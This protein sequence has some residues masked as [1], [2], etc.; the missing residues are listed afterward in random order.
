MFKSNTVRLFKL[1]FK[2]SKR[3]YVL[4]FINALVMASKA[5]VGVY[6][7][8]LIIT[9]LTK[10]DMNTALMYAAIIVGFEVVLRFLEI[11]LSAYTE[12][13]HDQ[14]EHKVRA[15]MVQKVM[16]VE[17]KYLENPDYLDAVDKAKFAIDSFDAL[18]I[19]LRHMIEL[20]TQFIIICSLITLII[21]FNPII[22]ILILVG[23][24]IHFIVG[25]ISSKKQKEYY[26]EV[27]STNRKYNYYSNV[28]TETNYQKDFRIYPLGELMNKRFNHFLDDTCQRIINYKKTIGRFQMYYMVINYMQIIA[29]YGF[30][31]YIAI[32]QDLGVGTYILLTASAMKVSSAIDG[33]ASRLIQIRQNVILLNSVFEVL[34]KEDGITTSHE[35]VECAKFK[36]LEFKN[37]TFTYPGTDKVILKNISF[38]I[39]KGEKISIVGLNGSGKTTIVKLIS[40]FYTT[41]SGEILWNG[42]NINDYEYQS[43][44]KQ[45]S[46]VFQDFKLF[47]LTIS[48]NVDLEEKDKDYIRECLYQVGL[49]EKIENL[50]NNIDSFLSKVYSASGID[51]SGGE[52]QKVAIARAM[53]QDSSLAILDEPTSALDPISEAEIYEHFNELVKDKT[54]IYI[55]HRMSSSIF[56]NR[57]IV[58]S[59]G[60]IVANDSHPNLMKNKTGIYYKLFNAQS[61]YYQ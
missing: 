47:A 33:F 57:I 39:S 9:S 10:S 34:D 14:L 51:M 52:K 32:T 12:I 31:A 1:T 28:V 15:H 42:I 23:V 36:T 46:A 25:Q 58:L 16:N 53:Y 38:K 5:L 49:K 22:I 27:G 48:E 37:V 20:I 3:F 54:T 11:T 40:R 6:G 21:F 45:V 4:S 17:F 18:N 55:S 19:F 26:K 50:P 30:V 8:S 43:F 2:L 24:S 13:A 29:I 56:C 41:D 35:G 60:S 61:N 59:D 7:L 44:I